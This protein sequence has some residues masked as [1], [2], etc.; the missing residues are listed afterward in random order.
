MKITDVKTFLVDASPPGGWSGGGR[1]WLFV[2]VETDA[3]IYGLGEA[4]G[5]PRVVQT[6]I[7]DLTP[8]VV[9]ED[10]GA[11]RVSLAEDAAGH[12]GTRDDRCGGRWGNDRNRNRP[13]GHP[14]QEAGCAGMRPTGRPPSGPRARVCPCQHAGAR[15][16]THRARLHLLQVRRLGAPGQD[17]EDRCGRRSGTTLTCALTCMGRPGSACRMPFGSGRRSKSMGCCSMRTR[18]PPENIESLAKVARAI[19]V[20]LACGERSQHPVRIS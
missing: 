12:D 6:A 16:R 5:W 18:L 3:G 15:A 13:L 17:G 8:V 20:P 2:K 11:D 4:S 9:G 19:D 10:P 7:E 1:N 14:G